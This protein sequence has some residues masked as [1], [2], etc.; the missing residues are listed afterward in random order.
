VTTFETVKPAGPVI[1]NGRYQVPDPATGEMREWTRA[2]NLAATL[3]DKFRLELWGKC[4]VALGLAARHDLYTQAASCSSYEADKK[5]L[6]QIVRQ[7]ED[8]AKGKAGA[9]IGSSLHRFIERINAGEDVT[10]PA[11]YDRDLA[12][13]EQAMEAY[14]IAILDGWSERILLIPE[15][16]V[17]GTCDQLTNAMGW[18]LPRIADVKTGKDVVDY[19]M[20][21]IPL[22]LAI[23]SRASHWYDPATGQTHLIDIPI[24]QNTAIVI[25]LPAGKATCSLHEVDIDAGWQAVQLAVDVRR[26][27]AR[28]DLAQQ[29]VPAGDLHA[30]DPAGDRAVEPDQLPAPA[31]STSRLHWVQARVDK[32][33]DTGHGPRLAELWSLRPEIPTFKQGGPRTEDELSAVIGM[34]DQVEKDT[35]LPFGPSDPTAPKQT[36]TTTRSKTNA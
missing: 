24:D 20:V 12:I 1:K 13:Y 6:Y 5:T 4:M 30:P 17:A 27:R 19:G 25:H 31:L 22:Q 29:M 15:L 23:Y 28:K 35:G 2:T 16:D 36:K 7:A 21:E 32:I 11:P 9:N 18:P 33:K 8:A 3:A 26:W 14:G 34:C 10:A